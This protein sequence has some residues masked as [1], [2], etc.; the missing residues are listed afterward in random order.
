MLV[1]SYLITNPADF[2]G[3]ISCGALNEMWL[4]TGTPTMYVRGSITAGL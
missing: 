4:I 3:I 1:F 2:D